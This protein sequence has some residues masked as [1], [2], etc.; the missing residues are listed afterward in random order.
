M[1]EK[2]AQGFLNSVLGDFAVTGEAFLWPLHRGACCRD[3]GFGRK[4]EN[5]RA[6]NSSSVLRVMRTR[7]LEVGSGAWLMNYWWPNASKEK[8]PILARGPLLSCCCNNHPC[9]WGVSLGEKF[10]LKGQGQCWRRLHW[11]LA[12]QRPP[13]QLLA[14]APSINNNLPLESWRAPIAQ[15]G[16]LSARRDGAGRGL[17]Q[18]CRPEGPDSMLWHVHAMLGRGGVNVIPGR[19]VLDTSRTRNCM[20]LEGRSWFI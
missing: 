13:C 2:L 20:W 8:C 4:A 12:S 18:A 17:C 15:K 6:N 14:P 11:R 10:P 3:G 7:G 1:R 9:C 5:W 16:Q 19:Q